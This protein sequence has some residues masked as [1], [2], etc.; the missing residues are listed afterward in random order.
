MKILEH[1]STE[2]AIQDSLD[3]LWIARILTAVFLIWG[4][5]D[6]V[7]L[8]LNSWG[9]SFLL[10]L[11]LIFNLGLGIIL[12]GSPAQNQLFLTKRMSR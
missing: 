1:T 4:S 12:A 7:W 2:L 5:C 10:G 6:I 8:M 11:H 3:D 9:W